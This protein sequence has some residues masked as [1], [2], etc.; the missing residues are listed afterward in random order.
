[1]FKMIVPAM[2]GIA[3]TTVAVCA[4]HAAEFYVGE[5]IVR[6]GMQLA[7]A[8]LTGIQMDRM[9]PGMAMTPDAPH[10]EIDIHATDGESHGFP[11]DAWIPYLTVTATIEKPGSSYR[12]E[13]QLYPMTAGDGPHYA[14][15]FAMAG[16]G[17]YRITYV[18]QPPSVERPTK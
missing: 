2:L 14:N 5:P 18:V 7:P 17:D 12:E 4:V 1:M 10:F 15:N 11:P 16:P 8:Y 6:D 3:G 9:P 13:K